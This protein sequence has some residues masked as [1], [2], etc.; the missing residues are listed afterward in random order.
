MF[1]IFAVRTWIKRETGERPVR[2]RHCKYGVF[3]DD[4]P[5]KGEVTER[6]LGKAV[7]DAM[8]YEPGDLPFV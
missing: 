1:V 7:A 8:M 6:F 5:A 4:P 2:T 3:A